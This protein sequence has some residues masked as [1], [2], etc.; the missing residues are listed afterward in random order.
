VLKPWIVIDAAQLARMN[1]MAF[2][3]YEAEFA[4]NPVLKAIADDILAQR[5][6]HDGQV[7]TPRQLSALWARE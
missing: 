3:L 4:G 1:A 7:M 5:N 6:E 2:H